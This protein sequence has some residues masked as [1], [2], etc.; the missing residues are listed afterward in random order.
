MMTL[1]ARLGLRAQELERP[2]VRLRKAGRIKTVGERSRTRYYPMDGFVVRRVSASSG[3]NR[4]R[5]CGAGH[6][7]SRTLRSA[8]SSFLGMR[9]RSRSSR[10]VFAHLRHPR[11]RS[12]SSLFARRNRRHCASSEPREHPF[13]VDGTDGGPPS[14]CVQGTPSP[15]T[16]RRHFASFAHSLTD[17]RETVFN[18]GGRTH[19]YFVGEEGVLVHNSV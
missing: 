7:R 14:S 6:F 5:G 9:T 4:D 8:T 3:R 19:T 11:P 2:V 18:F 12:S 13:W 1:A 15:P 16:T 10:S 17:T